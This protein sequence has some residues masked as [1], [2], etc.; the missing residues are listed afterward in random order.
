MPQ[1][2][3]IDWSVSLDIADIERLTPVSLT[4]YESIEEFEESY[5]VML[6]RKRGE[7]DYSRIF[8][9]L[10]IE[11]SPHITKLPKR[12]FTPC[13]PTHNRKKPKNFWKSVKQEFFI[14][15]CTENKK[16]DSLR[17]K[18][19]ENLENGK[20]IT[21]GIIASVIAKYLG[22]TVGSITGF[23][24]ILLYFLFKVGKEAYCATNGYT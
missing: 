12:G 21:V 15:V 2:L 20:T 18:V 7:L 1:T 10:K 19:I 6:E 9:G 23:I 4:E 24:A 22:V 3:F 13:L 14:L 17:K 8:S 16:Y 11:G 5:R